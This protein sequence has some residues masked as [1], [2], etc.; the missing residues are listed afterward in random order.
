[1]KKEEK[2]KEKY[3]K[4]FYSKNSFARGLIKKRRGFIPSLIF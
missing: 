1:M 3:L 4:E 2:R